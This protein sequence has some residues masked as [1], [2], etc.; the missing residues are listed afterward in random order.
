MI[1]SENGL[2]RSYVQLN[3]RNRDMIGFVDEARRAVAEQVKLPAGM[4]LEWSGEF[5]HQMHARRTLTIILPIVMLVIFVLLYITYHDLAD[6]LL[7]LL[8]AVPGAVAGRHVVSIFVWLPVYRGSMGRLYRLLRTGDT[9]WI[10]N[11]CLSARS[12]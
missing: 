8:L 9:K 11:A 10:G 5:E 4:Y 2:L 7:V 12:H 3:V 1:K 6:T